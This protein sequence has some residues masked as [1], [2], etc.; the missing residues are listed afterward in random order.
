[1]KTLSLAVL[2]LSLVVSPGFADGIE[3]AEPRTGSV[4][5]LYPHEARVVTNG[6]G[7][8]V[9]SQYSFPGFFQGVDRHGRIT[10]SPRVGSWEPVVGFGTGYLAVAQGVVHRLDANGSRVGTIVPELPPAMGEFRVGAA[11]ESTILLMDRRPTFTIVDHEGKFIASHSLGTWSRGVVH[12]EPTSSGYDILSTESVA[13]RVFELFRLS[14]DGRLSAP[15]TLST[16]TVT[17]AVAAYVGSDLIVVWA[18]GR[19]LETAVVAPDGTVMRGM[20]RAV[21]LEPLALVPNSQGALLIGA[22]TGPAF[23]ADRAGWAIQLDPAGREVGQAQPISEGLPILDAASN[24]TTIYLLTTE[25]APISDRLVGIAAPVASRGSIAM[26]EVLSRGPATQLS[27]AMAANASQALIAWQERSADEIT[28]RGR[29]IAGGRPFGDA[30]EIHSSTLD[31][32][33]PLVVA[34]EGTFLVLWTE[35]DGLRAKRVATNGIVLDASPILLS[36]P[37]ILSVASNGRD[38]AIVYPQQSSFGARIVSQHGAA[39]PEEQLT[40]VPPYRP[41]EWQSQVL[42]SLTWDGSRYLLVWTQNFRRDEYSGSYVTRAEIRARFFDSELKPQSEETVIAPDAIKAVAVQGR[43]SLL[44]IAHSQRGLIGTILDKSL[45]PL[46]EARLGNG[47][48]SVADPYFSPH[49]IVATWDGQQYVAAWRAD[50][51]L[52][53]AKIGVTGAITFAHRSAAASNP[54]IASTADSTSI[55]VAE[56]R[57]DGDAPPTSR[58]ILYDPEDFAPVA[59]RRRTVRR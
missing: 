28:L 34:A 2:S 8:L 16:D 38:F 53:M 9:H 35:A 59:A 58:I 19:I 57:A 17:A 39:G 32:S 27:P 24:G 52:Y 23:P 20:H 31:I 11:N 25:P 49:N 47:G 44:L 41:E 40:T 5:A 12:I 50:T 30:I 26:K 10:G 51:T 1:M 4:G 6:E 36:Q 21:W 18:E 46:A 42:P 15:I 48:W 37:Y 56:Q 55:V 7:F 45:R 43:D 54:V 33:A 29:V 22:L 13:Q 3:V 14:N